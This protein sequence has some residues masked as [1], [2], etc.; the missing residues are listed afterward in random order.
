[1][2]LLHCCPG[3]PPQIHYFDG[4]E[5]EVILALERVRL[6]M[7]PG[8]RLQQPKAGP[9][10]SLAAGLQ[11]Q[12]QKPANHQQVDV[13]RRRA[14][15]LLALSKRLEAEEHAAVVSSPLSA[16]GAWAPVSVMHACAMAAMLPKDA[17]PEGMQGIQQPADPSIVTGPYSFL[18][19]AQPRAQAS[20]LPVVPAVSIQMNHSRYVP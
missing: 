15:E 11:E 14:G 6:M 10:C 1:M 9:L 5:E 4:E 7:H 2:L 12:A 18:V 17:V 20:A 19:R 3:H 16:L 8:E 13:M